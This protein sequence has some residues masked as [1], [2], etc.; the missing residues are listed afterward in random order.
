VTDGETPS[1]V[2]VALDAMGG[3]HA[4]TEPIRGALAAAEDGIRV[5]LVGDRETLAAALEAERAAEGDLIRI[6]HAPEVVSS[7][8]DGARAVRAKPDSSVA[9]ACR[10]VKDGEAQALVSPGHTG[11]TM[12]ASI[13]HLRR[14]PGVLR[15]GIAVILPNPE[16]PIVLIDAG[17]NAEARPEHLR[18][19]A[20]MGRLFARD[21]LGVP[22]P[23]VGLLSIGEEG[24]RGSELVLEAHALLRGSP[25]FVGN[26]E[27]RDILARV[28]DVVVTDGFTGNVALKLMEGTAVFMLEQVR[29]AVTSSLIGRIGGLLVRPS[30]RAMREKTHPDTY[31]GAYLLGVGGISVIGHGNG[32]A[33]AIAN[34]VRLAARG[35]HSDLVSQLAE[36][37]D[38]E[39]AISAPAKA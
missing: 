13:L 11:A 2:T 18:Q 22:S 3:D 4:P 7:A 25:G 14:V 15:P 10:L 30:L 16:G 23:T 38:Q 27:G 5:L 37:I 31:G 19:F 39:S 32:R 12:A 24:G 29:A 36:G 9:V 26:I 34:A 17:A 21:V 6:V 28:T 35:V 33:R 20:L 1:T 8:E